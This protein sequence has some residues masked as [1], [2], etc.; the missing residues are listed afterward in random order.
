MAAQKAAGKCSGLRVI[1]LG[2]PLSELSFFE[3]CISHAASYVDGIICMGDFNI[4]MLSDLNPRVGN[5][6][7]IVSL[8]SLNQKLSA[9]PLELLAT[10]LPCLI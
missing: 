4:D 2:S 8:F 10:L 1:C 3:L 5:I 6:K 9:L 7:D